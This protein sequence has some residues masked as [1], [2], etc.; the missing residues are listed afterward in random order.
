MFRQSAQVRQFMG[1]CPQH[2]I[3]FGDLTPIEHLN[4]FYDFK[5]GNPAK[6]QQEIVD[7]IRGLAKTCR[8]VVRRQQAQAVSCNC[9]VCR[10]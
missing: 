6:K 4:I 1:V 3:L 8:L 9:N 7:L 5:G 10:V 2:D